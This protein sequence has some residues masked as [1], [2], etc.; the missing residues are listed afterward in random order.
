MTIS[1]SR[2]FR[3]DPESVGKREVHHRATFTAHSDAPSTVT[4][5][6][7]GEVDASNSRE[8]AGYVQRHIAGTTH[9]IV[10]LRLVDF[11]GTAGF[12]ALHNI[13]VICCGADSTWVLQAGRRVRRLLEICD[14]EGVLPLERSRS[15]LSSDS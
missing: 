14:P 6:V 10:D 4:V 2:V 13:N 1:T 8:L 9:L 7:E 12:A 15:L 11:L 3:P 5:T